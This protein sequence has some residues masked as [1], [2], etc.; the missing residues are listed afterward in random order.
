MSQRVEERIQEN[1][2]GL[3]NYSQEVEPDPSQVTFTISGDIRTIDMFVAG[4]A[5]IHW[6][7][8][9]SPSSSEP[10]VHSY[11]PVPNSPLLGGG[12]DNLPF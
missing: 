10:E 2:N 7:Q 11:Y 4:T 1:N 12:A 3:R 6:Q 5:I 8:C 9:A